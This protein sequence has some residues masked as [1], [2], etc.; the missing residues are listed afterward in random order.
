MESFKKEIYI[1]YY[2]TPYL[3]RGFRVLFSVILSS[4]IVFYNT[5][6]IIQGTLGFVSLVTLIIIDTHGFD[7]SL[8]YTKTVKTTLVCEPSPIEPS[9][10]EP[11][12]FPTI[13]YML[14]NHP[15]WIDSK[16]VEYWKHIPMRCLV[17]KDVKNLY[18][19]VVRD[20][21]Q[22]YDIIINNQRS[23]LDW[24]PDQS[25][26]D[27]YSTPKDHQTQ[28]MLECAAKRDLIK[29]YD[30]DVHPNLKNKANVRLF[31]NND[32]SIN[33]D[34]CN[35]RILPP[36][37]EN[38]L[39]RY[40]NFN[41]GGQNI[42]FTDKKPYDKFRKNEIYVLNVCNSHISSEIINFNH[43]CVY[44]ITPESMTRMAP[45]VIT[46]NKQLHKIFI[47]T[48]C[49]M[50]R[51][52]VEGMVKFVLNSQKMYQ[53]TNNDLQEFWNTCVRSNTEFF[54]I[55]PKQF[56]T[57]DMC[58]FATRNG[59]YNIRQIPTEYITYVMYARLLVNLF[60]T[61]NALLITEYL[62]LI[63]DAC[64]IHRD[65]YIDTILKC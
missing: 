31:R 30:N 57:R 2:D 58:D 42:S 17:D 12:P 3:Q 49:L 29:N 11:S 10:I 21:I 15:D 1:N 59:S 5:I 64:L 24:L 36:Y 47:R 22:N 50:I 20:R 23:S 34:L 52:N 43:W 9:P 19:K 4:L 13:K 46:T 51:A 18:D 53:S 41:R 65:S 8:S 25:D 60:S 61:Q 26:L 37:I 35:L 40:S 7:V 33:I 54:D 44:N 38:I 14:K 32:I 62:P 63:N 56:I 27:W 6:S 55:V 48:I 16:N 28:H 39:S 45:N